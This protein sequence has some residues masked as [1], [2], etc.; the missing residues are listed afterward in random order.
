MVVR[1][2]AAWPSKIVVRIQ[3]GAPVRR[4]PNR[5]ASSEVKRVGLA[6]C[7][8]YVGFIVPAFVEQIIGWL[9]VPEP[10]E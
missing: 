2:G 5:T 8:P 3:P 9:N 1:R 4:Q 6:G 10:E 7:R